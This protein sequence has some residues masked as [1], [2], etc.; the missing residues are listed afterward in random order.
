MTRHFDFRNHRDLVFRCIVDDLAHIVLGEVAT[1]GIRSANVAVLAVFAIVPPMTPVALGAIGG[2]L[3]EF[4]M[5]LHLKSPASCI[6]EVEMQTVEL[7]MSHG[8]DLLH[9]K[10]LAEEMTAEVEHEA[11]VL[12]SRSIGDSGRWQGDSRLILHISLSCG[13]RLA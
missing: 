4:R 11:T 13:Y 2:L 3:G 5:A 12:E 8:I 7:V 1:I 10:L 6:S 9:H